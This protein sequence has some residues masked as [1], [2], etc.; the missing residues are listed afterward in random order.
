[1][2]K[3]SAI[4]A[5][6]RDGPAVLPMYE[7]LTK[8]VEPLPLEL[9]IIFV[10]DASPDD[11]EE[12]LRALAGRDPRVVVINHTRNFGSQAAFSSGMSLCTGDMVVLMDG[13]LQDPP[14]LIPKLYEKFLEGYE[15]VYGQRVKREAT[16]FLQFAYK[17]FYRIFRR[18]SYVK[19]PTDAGDFSLMDRKVVDALNALPER[20]RFLRGLRA[21]VG[22]RQTGVPYVRPERMFGVTTNSLLKNIAW[23]RKGIFSFSYLPLEWISYLAFSVTSISVVAILYYLLRFVIVRDAPPGFTTILLSVLFLGGI[24]LL[25]LAIIGD[26]LG[27]VFEEVKRRPLYLVKSIFNDPRK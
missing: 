4:I 16:L 26:Y 25:C 19:V 6:Y 9:E 14:E 13:D 5:C 24:Q 17:A 8:A 2:K 15:V 23:A 7:R 3:L 20:D 22:F 12:V 27:R 11:A 1:M 18:L 10:N 21:W